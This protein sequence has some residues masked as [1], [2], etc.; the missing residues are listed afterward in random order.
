M[1]SVCGAC[2]THLARSI[3]ERVGYQYS[4]GGWYGTVGEW[5]AE[6]VVTITKWLGGACL[7]V[8]PNGG[9]SVARHAD[10]YAKA[11]RK[12]GERNDCCLNRWDTEIVTVAANAD[13]DV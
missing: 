13:V 4:G 10:H 1:T 12:L 11:V 8:E 3:G 5:N 6:Y 2:T 7:D 9:P